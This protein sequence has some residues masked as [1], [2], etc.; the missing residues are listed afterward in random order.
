MIRDTLRG[1]YAL[2]ALGMSID[3]FIRSSY[4]IPNQFVNVIYSAGSGS[5]AAS[6]GSLVYPVSRN[7]GGDRDGGTRARD[8]MNLTRM[9][10]SGRLET[11]LVSP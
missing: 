10:P 8:R 11:A 7:C 9:K 2:S 3:I 5:V 6:V 4:R 1:E